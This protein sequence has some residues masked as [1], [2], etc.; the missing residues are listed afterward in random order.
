LGPFWKG[1]AKN[2]I[3]RIARLL[4]TNNL[5]HKTNCGLLTILHKSTGGEE[6]RECIKDLGF[7]ES[8]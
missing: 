3:Q 1:G 5:R 8:E 7:A 2:G 6:M 4:V